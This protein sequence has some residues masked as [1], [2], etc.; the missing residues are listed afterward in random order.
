MTFDPDALNEFWNV[1]Y[2]PEVIEVEK[3]RYPTVDFITEA[4]GG[5]CEVQSVPISFDCLDGFQGGVLW[6]SRSLFAKRSPAITV[7]FA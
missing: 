1:H 7:V 3:A 6:S 5:K 4:L 2:F